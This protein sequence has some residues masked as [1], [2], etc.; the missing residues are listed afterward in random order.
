M[1]YKHE[2]DLKTGRYIFPSKFVNRLLPFIDERSP[3]GG[4]V[5]MEVDPGC[6]VGSNIDID[7]WVDAGIA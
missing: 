7:L 6:T 4:K 5:L 3:P 2:F 1:L